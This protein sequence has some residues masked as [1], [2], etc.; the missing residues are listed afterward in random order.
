MIGQLAPPRS[1]GKTALAGTGGGI[2]AWL[3]CAYLLP[4]AP[5]AVGFYLTAFVFAFGSGACALFLLAD[6]TPLDERI[7]ISCA[8]G[9]AFA[10][11]ALYALA[12]LKGAFLF[13]PLA[14]AASGAAA[15]LWTR[16]PPTEPRDR[17]PEWPSSVALS[18]LVF[19][20]VF[21]VS[22]GRL[23]TTREGFSIFG[24]YDTFDLTYYAAIASELGHT[25]T[26]PPVSPFY[27]GHRIVYSYFPLLFLAAVHNFTGVGTTQ[28]FL[29]FAWPFF[30][31]VTCAALYAACRRLGSTRFA[32]LTT[33]LVFTG[34]GF[35]Y[36]PALLQPS[37]AK[38]D[39]LIWQS[40][41]LAPSAEWLFFNP[42]APALSLVAVGMY[43][44]VR[45]DETG[46]GGWT[47]L[48]GAAFGLVFMVKSFAF[49]VIVPALALSAAVLAM[50]KD[51][52]AKGLV[53][54]LAWAIVWAAPWILA[55]L[56]F[57]RAE[58]RG[59]QVSVQ[60]LSL[61][62][63]MMFKTDLIDTIT[64]YLRPLTGGDPSAWA[65]LAIATV[66]FIVGGL[67][68]RCLGLVH[69]IR[70]A[71]GTKE[72]R[73]WAPLAWI[74]IVGVAVPFAIAIAPFPNSI[75]THMFALFALWPFTVYAVWPPAARPSARR[76]VATAALVAVAIPATVHYA[77]A[78]HAASSGPALTGLDAGDL[79]IVRYLRRS[80]VDTTM[81]LH[82]NPLWPSLHAIESSRRVV[83]AWS[84]YVEGDG[85]PDVDARSAEIAR[86]FGS[87][88][89][90][91]V[92]DVEILRRYH[93]THVIERVATDRLHPS[94][95]Q[96]LRLL[97]GT[98]VVRLYEVPPKL[99]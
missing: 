20:L 72:M 40:M 23:T 96:Q 71:A 26:I 80:N 10:P 56:P 68:V 22:S 7:A 92:A 98:P 52:L 90:P 1:N 25:D 31:A 24:D 28:A 89:A 38:F 43:A 66:I 62:H 87:Q 44:I 53:A 47:V 33:L 88:A 55:V 21:W 82:S 73:L 42:W 78:A 58:N 6:H 49:A 54:V 65:V 13:P 76:W 48:A 69:V 2:L 84:S 35:A 83:L 46:R 11:M 34:S 59:A 29:A 30:S 3:L 17:G 27:A 70:A 14:F 50:R 57:N 67:G 60:W 12:L 45:A 51:R 16:K 37:W 97:T 93:V 77:R 79:A 8:A 9:V 64:G 19:A 5:G 15:A 39:Q 95:L 81:L 32:V 85:S 94:V 36:I 91:G 86:F 18:L 99:R 4:Q 41:F 63:R 61:V 74:V 75:Q